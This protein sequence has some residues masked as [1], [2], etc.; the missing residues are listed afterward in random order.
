MLHLYRSVKQRQP[1]GGPSLPLHLCSL[2]HSLSRTTLTATRLHRK[3]SAALISRVLGH[4]S[5]GGVCMCFCISSSAS[6]SLEQLDSPNP[7]TPRGVV[8][9]FLF[10][11]GVRSRNWE[12]W[13]LESSPCPSQDHL[14]PCNEEHF[15]PP[16][17]CITVCTVL[18]VYGLY[19]ICTLSWFP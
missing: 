4:L 14:I 15:I 5:K 8:L 1:V 10:F 12:R 13:N 17:R 3:M 11:K 19:I 6:H 7:R 18:P 9:H 2:E 16:K